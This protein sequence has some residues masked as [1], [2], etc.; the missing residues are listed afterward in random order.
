MAFGFSNVSAIGFPPR[1]GLSP[2][3][4]E[5]HGTSRKFLI[6]SGRLGAAMCKMLFGLFV[7]GAATVEV[8]YSRYRFVP[9]ASALLVACPSLVT[10]RA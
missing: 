1:T 3:G 5:L 2:S 6:L 4:Q 10:S 9:E 7:V 8:N